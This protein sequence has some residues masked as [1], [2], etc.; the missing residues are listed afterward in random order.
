MG[1]GKV[2]YGG[3]LIFVEWTFWEFF[4][5]YPGCVGVTL[6]FDVVA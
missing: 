2:G 1:F 5:F 6:W 4:W 3:L